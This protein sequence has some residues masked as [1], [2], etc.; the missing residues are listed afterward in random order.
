MAV[1]SGRVEGD[2]GPKL[3]LG[4][5]HSGSLDALDV[6]GSGDDPLGEKESGRQV[7]VVPG[8]PHRHRDR[9]RRAV[10]S[11]LRQTDLQRFLDR[12]LV[13]RGHTARAGYSPHFD[14]RDARPVA[15]LNHDSDSGGRSQQ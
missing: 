8:R 3:R 14:A 7:H 1:E 5:V 4:S 11:V 10:R 6:R 2:A 13:G 15:D 9:G 12:E